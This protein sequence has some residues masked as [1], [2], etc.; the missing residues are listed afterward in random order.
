MKIGEMWRAYCFD[1]EVDFLFLI[2]EKKKGKYVGVKCDFETN[3]PFLGDRYFEVHFNGS[4]LE[5]HNPVLGK[6]PE[7]LAEA[8]CTHGKLVWVESEKVAGK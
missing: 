1:Y 3:L 2:V 4:T 8:K 6:N 7:Y 5:G